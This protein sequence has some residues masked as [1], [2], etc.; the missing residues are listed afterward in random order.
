MASRREKLGSPCP[1]GFTK[2]V[3]MEKR[4]R[5]Q[6]DSFRMRSSDARVCFLLKKK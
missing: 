3:M 5:R 2:K 6:G 1:F 4:Y